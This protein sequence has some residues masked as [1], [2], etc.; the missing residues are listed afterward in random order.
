[1]AEKT[2]AIAALPPSSVRATKALLRHEVRVQIEETIEREIEEG[3]RLEILER[4]LPIAKGLAS[5]AAAFRS[6]LC[7][8][9]VTM[10][11]ARP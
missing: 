3:L 5:S 6:A 1:M 11:S 10:A 9:A 4:T 2:A 7:T 8:G